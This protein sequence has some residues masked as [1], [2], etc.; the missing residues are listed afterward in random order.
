MPEQSIPASA[1]LCAAHDPDPRKPKIVLPPLVCDSHAH[2]CGPASRY[3][4]WPERIYTPPDALPAQYR[5]M[6]GTLGV[7]RAVLVQPSVYGMDN[8][9]MLDA[10]AADPLRLRAVAVVSPEIDFARLEHMHAL[11]VRGVRCNIVDIKEGKG[12]LPLEMLNALAAKV[13]PL[14][15]H[16]EFLMHVDEFPDLDRLLD[17]FPVDVVFG[18]LGYMKT[19]LGLGAP[20]YQ[21][22]L[23]LVKS[24]RAWVK[25]TGPYRISS[26]AMPYADVVPFAHALVDAA[27]D[28]IVW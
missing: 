25:L 12:R 16:L 11:G 4:Y 18:H 15:W 26:G 28:R 23:R 2:V 9:A 10:L 22:L 19:G 20:G 1:P 14:G 21:A 24:G 5:H 17:G 3:P 27:P 7:E 13:R 8:T 6:L